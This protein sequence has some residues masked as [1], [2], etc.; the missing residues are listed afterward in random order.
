MPLGSDVGPKAK[1]QIMSYFTC[2]STLLFRQFGLTLQKLLGVKI[3]ILLF[4]SR[5][6]KQNMIYNCVTLFLIISNYATCSKICQDANSPKILTNLCM[7]KTAWTGYLNQSLMGPGMHQK[8]SPQWLK[9][10]MARYNRTQ[11]QWG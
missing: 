6:F 1:R 2:C 4:C 11:L 7:Y 10:M 3:C 5:G 9:E 8:R